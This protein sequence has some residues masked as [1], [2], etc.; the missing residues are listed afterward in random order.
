ME[1]KRGFALL[2]PILIVAIG[3]LIGLVFYFST[4]DKTSIL[5]PNEKTSD[6]QQTA[7]PSI[8][9]TSTPEKELLNL[10]YS[11]NTVVIKNEDFGIEFDLPKTFYWNGGRSTGEG[12]YMDPYVLGTNTN[13]YNLTGHIS[14]NLMKQFLKNPSDCSD[15]DILINTELSYYSKEMNQEIPLI[16][17]STPSWVSFEDSIGCSQCTYRYDD[18]VKILGENHKVRV[19]YDFE[20]ENVTLGVQIE[21]YVPASEKSKWK[22]F[23][24]EPFVGLIKD[25]PAPVGPGLSDTAREVLE[26][27]RY[28]D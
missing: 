8:P 3:V 6:L 24:T 11:S 19:Y 5:P 26:S 13:V 22:Y 2:L 21:G 15:T 7:T 18:D 9:T 25:V 12:P 17:V 20:D 28:T 1:S 16:L 10:D 23:G 14:C 4:S 27:I